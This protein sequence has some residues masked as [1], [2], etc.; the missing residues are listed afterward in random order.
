MEVEIDIT[1]KSLF[2]IRSYHVQEEDENI[3]DK[4]MKRLCYLGILKGFFSIFK[5]VM[6]ITRKVTKDKRVVTGF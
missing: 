3:M 2:F 4:E 1:D 6:L 5:L